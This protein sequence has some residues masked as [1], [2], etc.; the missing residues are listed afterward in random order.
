[1]KNNNKYAVSHIDQKT[2]SNINITDKMTNDSQKM[3][4]NEIGR[5]KEARK[6]LN[7]DPFQAYKSDMIN[8]KVDVRNS[9][10]TS[11]T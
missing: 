1:M 11:M 6:L 9:N 10:T 5:N 3:M 8:P 4:Q 2:K 7:S